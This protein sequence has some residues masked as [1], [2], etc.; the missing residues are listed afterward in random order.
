[1]STAQAIADSQG[2]IVPLHP[3]LM[4]AA[5]QQAP[6]AHAKPRLDN[7]G[8]AGETSLYSML[9]RTVSSLA[10]KDR[11]IADLRMR[12][13]DLEALATTDPL[14]A[15]LNRRG[16]D[17]ELTKVLAVSA[18]RQSSFS[19][20]LVLIDLDD[21][22][23]INDTYGHAAGDACL[24]HVADRLRATVRKSDAIA[25]LGGDEF[26]VLLTPLNGDVSS[27]RLSIIRRKLEGSLLPWEGEK[28]H[29]GASMGSAAFVPGSTLNTQTLMARADAALYR[30]KLE[31]RCVKA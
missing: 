4:H 26:A 17:E 25:R 7:I 13:R 18:R 14:T 5:Q 22:K 24:V 16:F 20:L 19:G 1:M 3:E 29:I 15:L 8:E 28:L 9:S 2:K 31:R 12:I 23:S 6:N 21:F 11:L 30:D 10:E 27:S